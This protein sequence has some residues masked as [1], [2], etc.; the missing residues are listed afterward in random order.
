VEERS[1]EWEVRTMEETKAKYPEAW[2]D[3]TPPI[4]EITRSA[5][6]RFA[7]GIGDDNPLWVDEEYG[8]RTRYGSILAPPSIVVGCGA[9]GI[10]RGQVPPH[11][12]GDKSQREEANKVLSKVHGWY[13]G[14]RIRW[15]R[16]IVAGDTLTNVNYVESIESRPTEF[17]GE[18]S[19]I[20]TFGVDFFNAAGELV[21]RMYNWDFIALR[22]ATKQKSKYMSL[23]LKEYW[24][25]E[26]L[27][28]LWDQYEKE[29]ENR[30]GSKPR[31]WEDV[32]VG[33]EWRMLKGPYTP[34]SGIAY[35]IGA[36]GETFIRTDRLMYRTYIR[37]HPA[38]GVRNRQNI[39]EPPVRVH[40]E[41]ELTTELGMPAAHDFGGQ[42]IA[43]LSQIVTDWMGDD[44]FLRTLEAKFLKFNYM[45]DVQWFKARVTDKAVEGADHIVTC[46]MEAVNQ[47]GELTTSGSA[48][49]MLPTKNGGG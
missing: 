23:N 32:E 12:R 49:V 29:Y 26:E 31:Y 19:F 48:T 1:S 47:R 41:G 24:S 15:Y 5:I 27:K 36:V 34:T 43:W 7:Y 10:I 38:V 44:G 22:E 13:G 40:W 39:P 18:D 9:M 16:R 21:C 4:P 33:E 6:R 14:S 2:S 45:G 28:E 35:V 37:D 3:A 8:S 11:F 30:S 20:A 46:V 25:D 17:A 42:R